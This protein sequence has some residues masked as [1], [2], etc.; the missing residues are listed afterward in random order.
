MG[1]VAIGFINEIFYVSCSKGCC[2]CSQAAST[3]MLTGLSQQLCVSFCR[4]YAADHPT[5]APSNVKPVKVSLHL[6]PVGAQVWPE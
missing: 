4:L 5:V 6:W 2:F 1:R 3:L